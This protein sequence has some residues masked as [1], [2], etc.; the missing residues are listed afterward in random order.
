[1]AEKKSTTRKKKTPTTERSKK[2]PRRLAN[3]DFDFGN[4]IGKETRFKEGNVPA[5]AFG[6]GNTISTKYEDI[7]IDYLYEYYDGGYKDIGRVFPTKGGFIT[8]LRQKK[9]ILLSVAS[10]DLWARGD[11][12]YARGFYEAFLECESMA[13]DLLHNGALS[14]QFDSSYSRV[15]AS[16]CFGIRE[17]TEVK[18][19]VE[20]RVGGIDEKDIAL[21]H[22]VEARLGKMDDGNG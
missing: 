22:R 18:Q 7:Y 13:G 10:V 17:K 4:E 8:W 20:A 19:E 16:A 6:K 3:G 21:I 12:E 9:K 15:L 5:N 2:D 14:R 1:M 11:A